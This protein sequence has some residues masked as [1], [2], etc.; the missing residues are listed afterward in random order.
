MIL[1]YGETDS[2]W[3]KTCSPRASTTSEQFIV[4][5]IRDFIVKLSTLFSDCGDR[6]NIAVNTTC[7]LIP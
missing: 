2:L 6:L 1:N 5:L 7:E 3:R 4:F